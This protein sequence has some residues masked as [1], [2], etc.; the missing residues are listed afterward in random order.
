MNLKLLIFVSCITL[1]SIPEQASAN[2]LVSY[3]SA[4]ISTVLVAA[5]A[6]ILKVSKYFIPYF[7]TLFSCFHF[8]AL[9][10]CYWIFTLSASGFRKKRSTE[11]EEDPF[12]VMADT[13]P[14]KCYEQLICNLVRISTF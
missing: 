14:D 13:D 1:V 12:D 5:G 11:E 6:V 2:N 3:Y 8:Q 7:V 4:A 10:M 9:H